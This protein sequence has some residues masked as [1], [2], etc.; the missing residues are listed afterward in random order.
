MAARTKT[1][2]CCDVEKPRLRMDDPDARVRAIRTPAPGVGDPDLVV[3]AGRQ[4]SPAVGKIG[5]LDVTLDPAPARQ[6]AGAGATSPSHFALAAT[7]P[8]VVR[9]TFVPKTNPTPVKFGFG[10]VTPLVFMHAT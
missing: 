9:F 7:N 10:S 1:V 3:L 4:V 5:V 8:L 6:P 2:T